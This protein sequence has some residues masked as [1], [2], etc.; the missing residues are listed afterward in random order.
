MSAKSWSCRLLQ[1]LLPIFD[2]FRCFT[3]SLFSQI[4]SQFGCSLRVSR[5]ELH[6]IMRAVRWRCNDWLCNCSSNRM[7]LFLMAVLTRN[8]QQCSVNLC[9]GSMY[10]EPSNG[11]DRHRIWFALLPVSQSY[12]C[13][14]RSL[15]HQ[16]HHRMC[17]LVWCRCRCLPKNV[18]NWKSRWFWYLR[19]ETREMRTKSFSFACVRSTNGGWEIVLIIK[20]PLFWFPSAQFR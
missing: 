17:H 3:L 20:H 10:D 5:G 12:V 1:H 2:A 15:W 4:R 16:T 11:D 19:Q 7:Y 6:S 8:R 13:A 14:I 18:S 9:L